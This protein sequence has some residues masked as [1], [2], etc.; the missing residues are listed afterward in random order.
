MSAFANAISLLQ[1]G[2][3]IGL[4]QLYTYTNTWRAPE[5]QPLEQAPFSAEQFPARIRAG[6][7]A[8]M[9]Q[10]S[11]GLELRACNCFL[12][13][14]TRAEEQLFEVLGLDARA[15]ESH[16]LEARVPREFFEQQQAAWLTETYAPRVIAELNALSDGIARA[17][18]GYLEWR[19]QHNY[20]AK[21]GADIF[22]AP[23]TLVAALNDLQEHIVNNRHRAR[24]ADAEFAINQMV[25]SLEA[26][27]SSVK[28]DTARASQVSPRRQRTSS[29]P[30][31]A[32]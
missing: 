28:I 26:Y 15:Y 5:W 11:T 20:P 21:A 17:Q 9:V 8:G 22:T 30:P 13:L 32:A 1:P 23:P 24:Q 16:R 25:L 12:K 6:I 31:P 2:A 29:F 19:Q 4:G 14:A 27:F 18:A 3:S 10:A 7:A